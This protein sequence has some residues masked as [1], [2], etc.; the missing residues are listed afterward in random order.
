V[1]RSYKIKYFFF[2]VNTRPIYRIK[3]KLFISN[4]IENQNQI[5]NLS[6]ESLLKIMNT[7]PFYTKKNIFE[8]IDEEIKN[9]N[10]ETVI[11]LSNMRISDIKSEIYKTK[12][13]T[14]S[15]FLD[16]KIYEYENYYDVYFTG[17]EVDVEKMI[18]DLEKK[19]NYENFE[20]IHISSR[21]IKIPH[22][23]KIKKDEKESNAPSTFFLRRRFAATA[24]SS[25]S[26]FFPPSPSQPNQ[27]PKKHRHHQ[28]RVRRRG[29]PP[30]HGRPRQEAPGHGP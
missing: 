27:K 13:K 9:Y 3:V 24:T 25:L 18:K 30:D 11:E 26:P 20:T 8:L 16:F 5:N 15:D 17:K 12:Y 23:F 1:V 6:R 29:V 14:L 10:N 19:I 2:Y 21:T 28:G 4:L 22:V 7:L